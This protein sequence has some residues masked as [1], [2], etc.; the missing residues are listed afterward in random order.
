MHN[1]IKIVKWG[2]T[3]GETCIVWKGTFKKKSGYKVHMKQFLTV[4]FNF[5]I[6]VKEIKKLSPFS[7]KEK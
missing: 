2:T 4:V 3:I 1:T 6:E 7:F 5:I